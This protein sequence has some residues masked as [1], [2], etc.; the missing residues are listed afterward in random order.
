M[1]LWSINYLSFLTLLLFFSIAV[2]PTV[3]ADEYYA[4]LTIN[5]DEAGFVTINGLTNYPDLL[6]KDS[7]EYTSKIKSYWLLNITLD[8]TF[9]DIIYDVIFPI[10]TSINYLKA[11]N[12]IRL[13]GDED[14]LQLKGFAENETLSLVVQYQIQKN[15]DSLASFLD[16]PLLILFSCIIAYLLLMTILYWWFNKYHSQKFSETPPIVIPEIKGLN[17]RQKQILRLLEKKKVPLTQTD[18]QKELLIPKAA[19]SRNIRGLERKGLI[20]KE[21]IG[22]SN[23]I[24]IKKP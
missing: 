3:T 5:I 4:D 21:Q 23:L 1:N 8:E 16:N 11:S 7:P 9:S 24:R 18:I 13:E 14:G 22:M 19:V 6:V 20:E 17:D 15:Q 2:F 12:S 10:G